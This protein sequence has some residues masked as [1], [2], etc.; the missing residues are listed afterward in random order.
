[1]FYILRQFADILDD[2]AVGGESFMTIGH[3]VPGDIK[4]IQLCV[5]GVD[6]GG[7]QRLE[8]RSDTIDSS[9]SLSHRL[10]KC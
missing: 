5:D 6:D 7:D 2:G 8:D 3:G 1:M 4:L 9:D 10:L